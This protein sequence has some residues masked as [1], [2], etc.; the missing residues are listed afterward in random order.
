MIADH[1]RPLR[2]S[3]KRKRHERS[4]HELT[5]VGNAIMRS[6]LVEKAP[7]PKYN[8]RLSQEI[9]RH[10][11]HVRALRLLKSTPYVSQEDIKRFQERAQVLEPGSGLLMYEILCLIG[12]D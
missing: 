1:R 7:R 2:K 4:H 5:L 3:Q 8:L 9:P 12:L 10:E 11:L 6:A